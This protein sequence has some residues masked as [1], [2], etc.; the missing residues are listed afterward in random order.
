[1]KFLQKVL[2]FA[3]LIN[4]LTANAQIQKY[5]KVKIKLNGKDISELGKAG[6]TI[7]NGQIRN[8]DYF[9]G[10]I[11]EN[12]I[13]IIKNMGLSCEIIM[14]DM[15]NFYVNRNTN[16]KFS[17]QQ[18]AASPYSTPN[19]FKLGTMG[20]FFT[21]NELLLELDTM[22]MLYPNLI[23]IKHPVGIQNTTEGRQQIYVKISDNPEMEESEPEILY[24][25]LTHAREP[26]GMQQM[27]FYMY[28]LLENY[29][30][31]PEIKY[32]VDNLEM[33][34]V[35]CVNPDGYEYNYTT[36]PT[37]GGMWRKNRLNNGDGSYG[38][39]LNRNY[40]FNWGY[41]NVGS[42]PSTNAD[43]YRG[44]SG[45]SEIETSMMKY[46][47]EHRDFKMIID[48]HCFSNVLITPWGYADLVSPDTAI[49]R[50]YCTLMTSENNF[51]WGTP[52]Q[53]IGYNANGTSS[54]WFYGEQNTKP[55]ILAFSPEAGSPDDGFWP[56]ITNIE[57]ICRSNMGMNLYLA[58][59]ALRYA[60]ITDL[61]PTFIPSQNSFIKFNLKCLG[62]DVPADFTV[63]LSAISP[64]ISYVGADKFFNN[65]IALSSETD[66]IDFSLSQSVLQGQQIKFKI[67]VNNGLYSYA[68]TLTKI[69]GQ[70]QT[71]FS[72][73]GNNI[74]NWTTTTGWNTTT[75]QS[76]SPSS[77]ITDSPNSDY[78]TN[79]VNSSITTTQ[80]ISLANAANA[81]LSYWA[82]WD[83]NPD[84][85]YVQIKIS[86]NNGTTW[87]PL[88]GQH[89]NL[90]TGSYQ[91]NNQPLYDGPNSNWVQENIDISTYIGQNV[92]FRF[93]LKSANNYYQSYDGFYFDDFTVTTL[94]VLS[95]IE[96]N[97]SNGASFTLFPNPTK[98]WI[99]I[100][101]TEEIHSKKFNLM[102]YNSLG[103]EIKNDFIS[104][105]SKIDISSLSPG[106]YFIKI[107]NSDKPFPL[108]RFTIV[109]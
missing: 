12:E 48:Y 108:Q 24:S 99:Q 4:S 86:T 89:T 23:T 79:P 102:I 11:S 28:Y 10:E 71:I 66:S 72:D 41:D 3:L 40:G 42:S 75:T 82:R 20:G 56:Q 6:I 51:I 46:F 94:P 45:F 36:N 93:T 50:P 16:L 70:P 97:R 84:Q 100:N 27:I 60:K 37:G 87:I 55:K 31:D 92:K 9:I 109:K 58:R 74:A 80:A 52:F 38:I 17:K 22:K 62:L 29:N 2:I 32:L 65:M 83:L 96:E 91:P 53:T 98:N 67:T 63:S 25:A 21:Y 15:A 49:Y 76:H 43:T 107:K 105:N 19:H 18:K 103:K 78:N 61:T 5:S 39:D 69:F 35:P 95:T 88:T 64:E 8:K 30:T 104:N 47:C 44:S 7:E 59:L 77:S 57:N 90:G 106:I 13:S 34:F 101:L 73:N 85:D 1:M 14:D 81:Y 68:D 26:A 54:D 33:Y